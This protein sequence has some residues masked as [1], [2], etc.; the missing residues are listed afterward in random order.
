MKIYK[1]ITLFVTVLLIVSC[2]SLMTLKSQYENMDQYLKDKNYKT[3]AE[4][5]ERA[6]G[7][8]FK[9]K[10][11]V[12]YLIDAGLLYHYMG[13]YSK[14]NEY[15]AKAEVA[16]EENFSKSVTAY[17]TSLFLNDN[18]LEYYGEDYEDIYINVFKAMN[19]IH[20]SNDNAA[21]V[22]INR[23]DMKLKNLATKYDK[24]AENMQEGLE[25]ETSSSGNVNFRPKS[26]RF[27]NDILARYISM[28]LY[29]SKNKYDDA[30]IDLREINDAY[31]K[32][33]NLYKHSLPS[34]SYK[35]SSHSKSKLNILCFSG[36]SPDKIS[37]DYSITTY[38]NYVK[39]VSNSPVYFSETIYWEGT[40][41]YHFKFSLPY[42]SQKT[43][44]VDH[45][46]V[47]VNGKKYTSTRLLEDMSNIAQSLFDIKQPL[48]YL[49]S[50]SRSIVK[51]LLAEEGKKLMYEKI[52]NP[53]LALLA[54]LAT[55]V[56]VHVSENADLRISHLF[57][58]KA[59]I[60]N[61][62]L[63]EGSYSISIKYYDSYNRLLYDDTKDNFNVS[64]NKLNFIESVFLL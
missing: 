5:I 16:I 6:K 11:R 14:S 17:A 32:Q 44:L 19:Y 51:G 29:A 38:G 45:I 43:S 54:G 18:A 46:D 57:P 9:D 63:P 22:E 25:N 33:K 50:F 39:V 47:Y 53:Y 27:H 36:R 2:G 49:K 42:M 28:L 61:I 34:L 31:Y 56:G 30:A 1:R 21:A 55:D 40:P 24:M 59:H 3:F 26:I 13:N 20:M 64:K 10:D 52:E 58:A 15:L 12:L 4:Q 35:P 8:E 48:I 41:D 23:I 60:A 7:K 62:D 37:A